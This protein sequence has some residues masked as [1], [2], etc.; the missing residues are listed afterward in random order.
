MT[1]RRPA[2]LRVLA[3]GHD[4]R[5][6]AVVHH[7]GEGG[8]VA[9]RVHRHRH[10]A[11]PGGAEERL[12]PPAPVA[13]RDDHPVAPA[14]PRLLERPGRPGRGGRELAEGPGAGLV[15]GGGAVGRR[16]ARVPLH[17][18]LHQVVLRPCAARRGRRGRARRRRRRERGLRQRR[19][20]L[21]RD[22][23][24]QHEHRV[25][26]A[27]LPVRVER[28][29]QRVRRRDDAGPLQPAHQGRRG[30]AQRLRLRRQ[31]GERLASRR[32]GEGERVERARQPGPP[33]RLARPVGQRQPARHLGRVGERHHDA[34]RPLPRQP[35]QPRLVRG[36]PDRRAAGG[37]RPGVVGRC[38]R[39]PGE[40][41]AHRVERRPERRAACRRRGERDAVGAV[42]G[43]VRAGAQAHHQPALA[44]H[45]DDREHLRGDGRGA[46][47]GRQHDGA[48]AH[49]PGGGGERGQGGQRVERR[50]LGQA[51]RG[52][53]VVVH[54]DAVEPQRLGAPRRPADLVPGG[55]VLGDPDP[56]R[57]PP[58]H[59]AP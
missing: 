53:E 20:G 9:Q 44:D 13:Q 58:R 3:L 31:P 4:D 40:H 48:Q 27:R 46:V 24:G 11:H 21:G 34:V 12:Q 19:Q 25:G 28:A 33:G 7:G 41:P 50:L 2:A 26:D 35:Q 5:G 17:H 42:L 36:E 37:D 6:L 30:R 16:A 8:G 55:A 49:A 52:L 15:H 14:G 57:G 10:G 47:G 32:H 51:A 23:R 18:Q 43:H 56:D 54:P 59:A 39:R 38:A 22:P 1:T 29:R 45:V